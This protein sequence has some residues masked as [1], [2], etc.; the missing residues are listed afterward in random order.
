MS[1][2]QTENSK[3]IGE[4][5]IRAR[6]KL[7]LSQKDIASRLNLK[8]EIITALDT[9]NFS[10]LPA[11]T[12]VR[13]YIRSYARAVN[14]NADS[15]IN[16]YEG[17]AEEPPEILPDVK[18]AVQASSRDKPVKAMTYLITFTLMILIIAW[19]QGQHIVSTDFFSS[20]VKTSEGGEYPGG[21]TY[22]YDIVIHPETLVV[23]E[24]DA[25]ENNDPGNMT[26]LLP[27]FQDLEN[28]DLLS[29]NDPSNP[30]VKTNAGTLKMELTAESWIEVSDSVGT[31]LYMDLAKPGEKISL[32]G[33]TPL[34]VK[35]G[36]ARAVSVNFNGKAFD[37]S[38][39]T[40]AGVA[41]FLLE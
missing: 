28:I 22:T 6:E 13:G 17:T 19:W 31:M 21:F 30:D 15:L 2:E 35:F 33:T 11:P 25:P 3:E 20:D 38:K 40:K 41:R 36:N 18:P 23:T 34:S 5:L 9:N 29:I 27:E 24:M 8:E 37:T 16:I 12:Y 1:V 26:E 32:T 4:L 39:Y 14:L 10:K 7:D